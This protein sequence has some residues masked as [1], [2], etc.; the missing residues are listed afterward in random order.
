MGQGR[1]VNAP[2]VINLA[3]NHL[4]EIGLI[5]FNNLQGFKRK[6]FRKTLA[7]DYF[8]AIV[9]VEFSKETDNELDTGKVLLSKVGQ[10]LAP[11]SG[12]QPVPGFFEYVVEVW[13]KA[14]IVVTPVPPDSP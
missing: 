5:T 8:K 2:S 3:L 1:E 11:I 13:R 14:G 4:D 10:E 7:L 6:G 12:S 9:S